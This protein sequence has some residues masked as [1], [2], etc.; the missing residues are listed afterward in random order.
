MDIDGKIA[1]QFRAEKESDRLLAR[2]IL[3]QA[4]THGK[5]HCIKV[6]TDVLEAVDTSTAYNKVEKEEIKTNLYNDFFDLR[7]LSKIKGGYDE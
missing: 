3:A 1:Y 2:L 4:F 7:N 5:K 6:L